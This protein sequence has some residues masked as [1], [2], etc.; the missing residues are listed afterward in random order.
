MGIERLALIVQGKRT[1]FETD[2]FAPL[3]EARA[4]SRRAPRADA[5]RGALR[6]ARIIADHVRALTF[7]IAEGAL[8]G[9]EGAGYVLRRLLR[10]A[11]TRGRSRRGLA[12]ERRSSAALAER[13]IEQLR[14]PLSRAA[15]AARRDPARA[16]RR[17]RRRSSRPSRPGSRGSRSCCARR[18]ARRCSRRRRVRAPRHLRLPDRAD[19]GDR[20]RA[21]A[22]PSTATGF[23]RAMDEQ[24]TRARAA[25]KFEQGRGAGARAPWTEV[26]TGAGLR[27]PR[28]RAARRPTAS[29]CARW[30]AARRRASSSWCSTARRAT[31]SRAARSP[32]A[33]ALEARRARRPS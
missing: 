25:S 10:R 22:S 19:R 2:L 13:V 17:R 32:T 24:R 33:G 1:I 14:R 7:A 9:N 3:V 21:R 31:P 6:D 28:L 20:A 16:R 27:V 11:V 23:E 4:A 15:R 12:I 30:R 26:T 5:P 18:R 8:P 29:R